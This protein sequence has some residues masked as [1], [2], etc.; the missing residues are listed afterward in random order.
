MLP[1]CPLVLSELA[2]GPR[3]EHELARAFGGDHPGARSALARL[4]AHGL[5]RRRVFAASVDF[6]LTRRGRRELR[7]QRLIWTRLALSR[8]GALVGEQLEA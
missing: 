6:Q 2:R 3:R 8:S 4:E 1:L 7:L 5:V